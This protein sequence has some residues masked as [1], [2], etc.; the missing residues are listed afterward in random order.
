[1]ISIE[2]FEREVEGFLSSRCDRRPPDRPSRERGDDRLELIPH[3]DP[4]GSELRREQDWRRVRFDAGLG[5]ITG[6]SEFGGRELTYDYEDRYKALEARYDTPGG[7]H[8]GIGLGMVAPTILAF[9]APVVRDRWLRPIHRGDAVGCQL[10]SEPGAGSDLASLST[11]AMRDGDG[12]I[13]NGQK[14]WTSEAHLADVGLLLARSD[15]TAPKH[16]GITAFALD[17]HSPGVTV[18]PLRQM[19]GGASFNEVFFDE[20][21]VPDGDR[22]GDVNC[23]WHVARETLTRERSSIGRS[24]PGVEFVRDGRLLDVVRST[25]ADRDARV[26]NAL[27]DVYARASMLRWMGL[28]DVSGPIIKLYATQVVLRMAAVASNALG[29]LMVADTGAWGTY[30]WGRF[31]LEIPGIRFGGGTDEIQRNLIAEHSLGLPREHLGAPPSTTRSPGGEPD[32]D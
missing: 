29:P 20:V 19:S 3:P 26:R 18:R 10:F 31:E 23:G 13:V 17:M 4:L 24:S 12:W 32:H 6:P 1:M 28:R 11:R 8:L 30:A 7:R 22:L 16:H 15:P 14:V 9:G 5:W 25:G 27:A 2:E 21:H